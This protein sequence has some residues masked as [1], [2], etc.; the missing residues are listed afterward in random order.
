MKI[1]PANTTDSYKIAKIWNHYIRNSV[2][3]FNSETKASSEI[4]H[5]IASKQQQN[6]PFF[7]MTDNSQ[8]LGFATYGPFRS[9]IGYARVKEH[10]IHLSPDATG[11]GIGRSLLN[12]LEEH[13]KNQGIDS[14]FAGVAAENSAGLRFHRACGYRETLRLDRVGYKFGRWHDLILL[15]K[16]LNT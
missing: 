12:A 11:K 13:A 15:R 10:T 14:L 4:S 2:A 6:E 3:T 9:G 8:I 1:R 16:Y 5:L 7:V